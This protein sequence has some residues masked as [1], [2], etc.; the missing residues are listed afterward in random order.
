MFILATILATFGFSLG[1]LAWPYSRALSGVSIGISLAML[2]WVA[3]R[4]RAA[5]PGVLGSTAVLCLLAALGWNLLL[6]PWANREAPPQIELR[7]ANG[8]AGAALIVYHPGRSE[9]QTEAVNGFAEGLVAADWRVTLATANAAAPT[10]L[11]AY[12]LLVVGAQSYTWAPARPVQAYLRR[13][14]N[15]GGKPVVA[16]LSGLGETGPATTVMAD[17]L[18]ALNGNLLDIYH[19]WQIRPIDELYGTDDPHLAMRQTAVSL[20]A[21]WGK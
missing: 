13:V 19:V 11:A 2:A 18:A 4:Q 15:L 3:W 12:D 10:D 6:M 1:V 14:G 5:L 20:V 21:A 17:L 7:N 9:L 8:T 16:I